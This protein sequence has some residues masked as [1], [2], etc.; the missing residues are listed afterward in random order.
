MRLFGEVYESD[1]EKGIELI[2]ERLKKLGLEEQAAVSDEEDQFS[3]SQ[4]SEKSHRIGPNGSVYASSE[5]SGASDDPDLAFVPRERLVMFKEAHGAN[6][7]KQK[8]RMQ[9]TKGTTPFERDVLAFVLGE[10]VSCPRYMPML[11]SDANLTVTVCH[12]AIHDSNIPLSEYSRKEFFYKCHMNF[13]TAIG[14]EPSLVA[15]EVRK[16]CRRLDY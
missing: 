13:K 4:L 3:D 2:E 1:A 5:S 14:A 12:A 16:I 6:L 15:D 8:S 9:F 11:E 10:N 7:R